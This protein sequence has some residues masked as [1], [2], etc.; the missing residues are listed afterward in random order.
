M[1][2]FTLRIVT[3]THWDSCTIFGNSGGMP[4]FERALLLR[5]YILCRPFCDR[6]VL[7]TVHFPITAVFPGVIPVKLC[8]SVID[9]FA[10]TLIVRLF[11]FPKWCPAQAAAPPD[12]SANKTPLNRRGFDFGILPGNYAGPTFLTEVSN[13]FATPTT[14]GG[15]SGRNGRFFRSSN[16]LLKDIGDTAEEQSNAQWSQGGTLHRNWTFDIPPSILDS[17]RCSGA[18]VFGG[19]SVL[20]AAN[21]W[22]RPFTSLKTHRIGSRLC[23]IELG[24]SAPE[25]PAD[26]HRWTERGL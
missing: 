7:D 16:A 24:L 22:V 13:M 3:P 1:N 21:K 12:H 26:L 15:R 2:G 25:A 4:I 20:L 11:G 18:E 14:I 17:A 5:M 23:V 10:G 9:E 8:H 6:H 19:R